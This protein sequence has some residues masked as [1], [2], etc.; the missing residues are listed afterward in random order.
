V[1]LWVAATGEHRVTLTGHTDRVL[2]VA[3][4]PDGRLL[5]SG[6]ADGKMRLWDA[7]TGEHRVTLTGHTDRVLAVAFSPGG[8]LLASGGADGKVRLWALNPA[9]GN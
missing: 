2:A 1:W 6:G 3:F 8:R 9:A 4:S 7:A 5:A